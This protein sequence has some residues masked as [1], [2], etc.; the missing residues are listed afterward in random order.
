MKYLIIILLIATM[1]AANAADLL[2]SGTAFVNGERY[3][4]K[5]V[6]RLDATSLKLSASTNNGWAE[7]VVRATPDIYLGYIYTQNGTKYWINF[8]RYTG[9]FFLGLSDEGDKAIGR[10]EFDGICK[11]AE[12]KF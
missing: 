8:H 4:T 1:S 9:E 10:P 2:C 5:S 12:R 7:G 6:V 11:H 3:E